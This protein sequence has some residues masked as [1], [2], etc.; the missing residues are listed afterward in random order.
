MPPAKRG[1]IP[2]AQTD[3]KLFFALSTMLL[4][5]GMVTIF[6]LTKPYKPH[7]NPTCA[8]ALTPLITL[9]VYLV[10]WLGGKKWERRTY[11]CRAGTGLGHMANKST[12]SGF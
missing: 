12:C 2:E 9:A 4:K 3:L 6:N 8:S 1:Q 5:C 11:N 7:P 10:M